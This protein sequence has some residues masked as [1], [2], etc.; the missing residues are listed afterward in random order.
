MRPPSS[1]RTTSPYSRAQRVKKPSTSRANSG[2]VAEQ[3]VRRRAQR[4]LQG[5]GAVGATPRQGAR[6]TTNESETASGKPFASAMKK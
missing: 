5:A 3:A 6:I 4:Q 2:E 1:P